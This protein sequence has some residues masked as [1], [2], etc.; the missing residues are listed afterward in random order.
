MSAGSREGLNADLNTPQQ[1]GIAKKY[2]TKLKQLIT[3]GLTRKSKGDV[4]SYY[5]WRDCL[6][7]TYQKHRELMR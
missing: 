3:A 4:Y 1:L 6:S 5:A 2:Y 7:E